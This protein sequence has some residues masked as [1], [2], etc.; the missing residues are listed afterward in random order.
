MKYFV[1]EF[2]KTAD[3]IEKGIY[4]YDDMT[5]AVA[6][7]HSKMGAAM[8]NENYL[9]ETLLVVNEIGEVLRSEYYAKPVVEPEPEPEPE[10]DVE[11]EPN[12]GE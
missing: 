7:F 9:A 8:K 1:T 3:K 10:P 6:N 2:T 4:E 11:P 12:E 5:L